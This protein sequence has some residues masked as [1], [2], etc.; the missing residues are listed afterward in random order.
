MYTVIFPRW[1]FSCPVQT[2]YLRP[3]GHS[4]SSAP[5]CTIN[6]TPVNPKNVT[7]RELRT[8]FTRVIVHFDRACSLL[9]FHLFTENQKLS[10]H[11]FLKLT[12]AHNSVGGRSHAPRHCCHLLILE[13]QTFI[14]CHKAWRVTKA[15]LFPHVPN[16]E[17]KAR[18][19]E[20]SGG[21]K[22]TNKNRNTHLNINF[23][24]QMF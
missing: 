17:T 6:D 19:A 12:E 13:L 15:F 24:G 11:F 7:R 16:L 5:L 20:G 21:R 23:I 10:T 1:T 9:F 8:L 22:H 18:R 3:H 14:V 4:C 2:K